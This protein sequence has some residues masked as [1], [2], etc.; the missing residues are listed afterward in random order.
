MQ[1]CPVKPEYEE[2]EASFESQGVA[3]TVTR[4]RLT[5]ADELPVVVERWRIRHTPVRSAAWIEALGK[6]ADD[7]AGMIETDRKGALKRRDLLAALPGGSAL[8]E[9]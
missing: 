1:V 2:V 5:N 4:W 3:K 6:M 8:L 7:R 9:E